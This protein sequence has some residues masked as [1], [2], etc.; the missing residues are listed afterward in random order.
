MYL[1]IA[2]PKMFTDSSEAKAFAHRYIIS[3]SIEQPISKEPT[4]T[5][6]K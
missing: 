4:V 5:D 3:S 1:N 6:F 2:K